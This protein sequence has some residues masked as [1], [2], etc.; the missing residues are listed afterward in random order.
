MRQIQELV[1]HSQNVIDTLQLQ[2]DSFA[3]IVKS[4]QTN[5][6]S[7]YSVDAEQIEESNPSSTSCSD[8]DDSSTEFEVIQS[9]EGKI[10]IVLTGGCV[11]KW[12]FF[13]VSIQAIPTPKNSRRIDT[14]DNNMQ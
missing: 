5:N 9:T 4:S 8:S 3:K 6:A 2:V 14:D 10:N 11:I 7:H 12:R 1:I 13:I